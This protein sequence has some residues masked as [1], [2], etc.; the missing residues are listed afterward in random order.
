MKREIITC[1]ICKAEGALTCWFTT[2][3]KMD[4]AGS[5]DDVQECLDLCHRHQW[6]AY[7][8]AEQMLPYEKRQLIFNQLLSSVK[9]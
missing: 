3:R 9:K 6:A 7:K 5:M 8:L 2:D 4:A 1:D